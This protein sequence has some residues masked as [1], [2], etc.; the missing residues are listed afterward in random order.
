MERHI[1]VPGETG[2]SCFTKAVQRGAVPGAGKCVRLNAKMLMTFCSLMS[3][4]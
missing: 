4:L 1:V 2:H 3:V